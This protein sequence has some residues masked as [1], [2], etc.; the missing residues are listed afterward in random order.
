MGLSAEVP[1]CP[2]WTVDDVVRHTAAVYLHKVEAIRR[3]VRPEPWP[4]NLADRDTLELYDEATAKLIA[5]L[6]RVGPDAPS[7]TFW[8]EDPTSGFWFRRMAQETAVHRVDAELAHD[9]VTP[10]DR[11]LAL[12]GIDEILRVMLGGPW[13][14]EGDTRYPVDATVRVTAN[15]RSWTVRA[16]ATAVTVT[17][18]D[19]GT[20]LAGTDDEVAAEDFGQADDL[21]LW[22]W[23]RRGMDAVQV[24]GDEEVVRSFRGRLSECTT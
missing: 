10:I 8:P 19:T 18:T 21:L 20:D 7:W 4:P 16:S 5:E 24:A 6:E 2:G 23:G 15:G 11:G 14:E 3:K 12:D 22:L 13:W 9:V 1:S 17:S